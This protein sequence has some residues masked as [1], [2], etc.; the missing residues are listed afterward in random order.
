M[1]KTM[2]RLS[3][4]ALAVAAISPC[5]MA[6]TIPMELEIGYRWANV[7]G[8][9][10]MYRS[11]IN[12]RA[13][14]LIRSFTMSTNDP[15]GATG[16]V[17]RFR[18]DVSDL[19]F[20]TAPA[21]SAR[22]DMGKTGVYRLTLGYRE[23]DQYSALPSFANPLLA[24]GVIPGQHTIDRTR[25]MFD[26]NLE[27][28]PGKMIT[29]IVGYGW[30]Q[31]KGPGQTTYF[32]G[33]DEF[34]MNQ[35]LKE[36][37]QEVRVGLG[38]NFGQVVY[39]QVLQ[40]WRQFKS[41][42]T[43]S[44]V[45]GAGAG[46]NAGPAL[47]DKTVS[48]SSMNQTSYTDVNTPFTNVN[49]T[50][51]ISKRLKVTGTY[52]QFNAKQDGAGSESD[53]GSFMSF[54]LD[55]FFSGLSQSVAA[56][57]ENKTWRGAGKAELKVTEGVDLFGG[58]ERQ[59][60]ENT[61]ASMIDTIYLQSITFGGLD[62]KDL[63][64][65][66]NTQNKLERQDDIWN[67]GVSART[68]GPL[69]FRGE[70]RQTNDHTTAAPDIAETVLASTDAQGGK[71]DRLVRTVDLGMGFRQSGFTAAVSWRRDAATEPI[72]RTDY[73]DRDRYRVRVGYAAP[74]D[75]IKA[76]FQMEGTNQSSSW[77]ASAFDGKS[78]QYTA[79]LE[80]AP[81]PALRLRG[82][83]SQFQSDFKIGYRRPENLLM[84]TSVTTEKGDA[85]EGGLSLR[86]SPVTFD[87]ALGRFENRGTNAFNIERYRMNLGW[88]IVKTAGIVAEWAR[89][90]YREA[91]PSL[92]DFDATRFGLYL[93]WRP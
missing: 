53:S 35:D 58:F 5:A 76:G 29:P 59:H 20:G 16:F 54:Q 25:K 50:A 56:N 72:F 55:R 79:D 81:V 70:Y 36:T 86:L 43:T 28:L 11:Q 34:R 78:R 63:E 83:L 13:G 9:E 44:L 6:Q 14:F 17:D 47:D 3:L 42:E 31:N 2:T 8:N 84:D 75:L 7:N 93:R 92:G 77:V 67:V 12:E 89:D 27:L 1:N 82:S 41:T 74:G 37:E 52:V 68:V 21:G 62:K 64:V 88:D 24:Q 26:A 65:L 69:S 30:N 46:N 38:F 87:I 22:I 80:I 48:A 45:P 90:K 51:D 23:A 66:L 49:V 39:G 71:F 40:G 60:R 18:V 61:G 85:Y 15:N 33:Q 4:L 32:L 73:Q 10:D 91:S 57:A 19:G